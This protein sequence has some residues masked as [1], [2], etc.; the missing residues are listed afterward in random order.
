MTDMQFWSYLALLVYGTFLSWFAKRKFAE[1]DEAFDL[2]I[3][4]IQRDR[5][6]K[7]LPEL[8]LSA[9]KYD[10]IVLAG[11]FWIFL[12]GSIGLVI[13]RYMGAL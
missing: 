10:K 11:S 13:G 7:N 3:I 2:E 9:F 5:I 12:F 1:S 4:K 6:R 8:K